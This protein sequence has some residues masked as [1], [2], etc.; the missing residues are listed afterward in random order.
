[1]T[2]NS[3]CR[4]LEK[5]AALLL[6]KI[7]FCSIEVH[8]QFYTKYIIRL[9]VKFI[10]SFKFADLRFP[11]LLFNPRIRLVVIFAVFKLVFIPVYTKNSFYSF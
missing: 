9:I 2:K 7:K 1:M 10:L 5:Y 3:N 4:V 11:K 6:S 8:A